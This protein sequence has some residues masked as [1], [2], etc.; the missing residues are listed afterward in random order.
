MGSCHYECWVVVN[1]I[2]L[3]M[4]KLQGADCWCAN[5]E[6]EG[7]RACRSVCN[8]IIMSLNQ[9]YTAG[10]CCLMDVVKLRCLGLAHENVHLRCDLGK[11]LFSCLK[12]FFA[13]KSGQ[14]GLAWSAAR[15]RLK[16]Q[17]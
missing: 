4:G 14:K 7:E 5:T 17:T 16:T 10:V 1:C 13:F 8:A 12:D 15:M 6:H 11:L 9:S 3:V 2:P